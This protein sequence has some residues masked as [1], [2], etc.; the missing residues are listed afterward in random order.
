MK[1]WWKTLKSKQTKYRSAKMVNE[2]I[3]ELMKI[4][5]KEVR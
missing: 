3:E 5:F 1:A 2:A 4:V